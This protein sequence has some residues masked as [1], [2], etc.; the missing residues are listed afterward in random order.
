MHFWENLWIFQPWNTHIKK[1]WKR[2]IKTQSNLKLPTFGQCWCLSAF[3]DLWAHIQTH[4]VGHQTGFSI[5]FLLCMSVFSTACASVLYIIKQC[6]NLDCSICWTN[7]L[8]VEHHE[9][10]ILI[11]RGYI[12]INWFSS[13]YSLLIYWLAF[14][15]LI[16]LRADYW[17]K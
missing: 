8:F 11:T 5:I 2:L 14:D 13:E 16:L 7:P 3:R 12:R 6:R 1:T 10:V 15:S 9:W 4:F 17:P